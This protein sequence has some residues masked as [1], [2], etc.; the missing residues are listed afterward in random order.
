MC[1]RLSVD[2]LT[3]LLERSRARG[4]AFSH[5]TAHRPWGLCFP[6]VPGL[7]VHVV[8]RGEAM[9]WIDDPSQAQRVVPGDLLLVRND[10]HHRLASAT[11]VD[12]T[13]MTD[14]IASGLIPGSSRRY[15]LGQPGDE[16]P[17][18]FFCGAYLFEGD[19]C[20]G[21]LRSLPDVIVQRPAAGSALR[22]TADLLA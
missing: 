8:V 1:H 4:A 3:D 17:A 14:H 13:P 22:A 10:A 18:E 11:D 20:D 2:V 9:L 21:L 15:R 5:T 6:P 19:L 7:S 12:C 16:E